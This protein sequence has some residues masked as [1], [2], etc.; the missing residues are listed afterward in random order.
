MV[1][2]FLAEGFELVEALA[3]VDIL[4]RAGAEV[5]LVGVESREVAASN[6]VTVRTDCTAQEISRENLVGMVLPGGLPGTLNLEKSPIVQE[7]LDYCV[8]EGKLIGAICAAPSILAHKGLLKG[9]EA[10]AFPKFQQDLIEGG[11]SLS[12]EYVCRDGQFITG[13]GMGVS[14]EFGLALAAALVS[15]EKAEEIK[16]SIQKP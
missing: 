15:P 1:Y 3:P 7:T 4:R 14:T 6:G 11:A 8:K 9:R 13:R 16:A 12:K 5:Q 10:T 2:V